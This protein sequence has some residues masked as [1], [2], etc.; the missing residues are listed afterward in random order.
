V[1]GHTA[2]GASTRTLV[3]HYV[4]AE[5]VQ[6]KTVALLKWDARLRAIIAGDVSAS[7]VIPLAIARD[8]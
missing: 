3:A 6:Q 2:A 8:A 4:S 5:F 7:N 1:I